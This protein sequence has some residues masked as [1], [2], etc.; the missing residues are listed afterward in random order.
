MR[1]RVRYLRSAG[2]IPRTAPRRTG[3]ASKLNNSCYLIYYIPRNRQSQVFSQELKKFGISQR[4]TAHTNEVSA[5]NVAARLG[6]S[7]QPI[8]RI[9]GDM[10]GVRQAAIEREEL[11]KFGI[12][13]RETAHTNGTMEDSVVVRNQRRLSDAALFWVC[14]LLTVGIPIASA[15]PIVATM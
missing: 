14:T 8:Y 12:S 2:C 10:D 3:S 15:Q 11:K 4:E 13:Q 7:T 5:R 6:I 9:F 1:W